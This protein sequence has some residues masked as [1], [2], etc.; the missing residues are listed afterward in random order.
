MLA[1]NMN[2]PVL[3]VSNSGKWTP[4]GAGQLNQQFVATVIRASRP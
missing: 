2:T 4:M 1:Q 3:L